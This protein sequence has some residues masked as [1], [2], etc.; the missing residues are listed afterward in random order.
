MAKL[1]HE[2]LIYGPISLELCVLSDRQQYSDEEGEAEKLGISSAQW[3]LFGVV[4]DAGDAMARHLLTADIEGKRVLEVGCGIGVS[5][6]ILNRR[7]ADITA[8]DYHPEVGK[9]LAR[10][11]EL[12]GDQ[13]IRFVQGSWNDELPE[14]GEFDL[15]VG[16]DLLYE[17]E[18]AEAL[19]K[20]VVRKLAEGGDILFADPGRGFRG[21]FAKKL[22]AAGFRYEAQKLGKVQIM[23][24]TR[25]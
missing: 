3:P 7:G 17:E 2:T 9:F 20:F 6:L 24:F 11:V 21:R 22:E 19:A 12:N 18:H 14:L 8:M 13:P 1:K 16:S 10:N 4:W 5:S 25:D 23:S 15:I